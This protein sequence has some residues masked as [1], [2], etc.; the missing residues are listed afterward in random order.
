MLALF[1]AEI[2]PSGFF[3]MDKEDGG[4][5]PSVVVGCYCCEIEKVKKKKQS[6]EPYFRWDSSSGFTLQ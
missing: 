4:I 5:A 6:V 2:Q 1:V 3:N